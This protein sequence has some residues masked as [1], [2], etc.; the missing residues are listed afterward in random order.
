MTKKTKR[1][2]LRYVVLGTLLFVGVVPL[3][4]TGWFLS[5]RSGRELRAAEGRYQTELVRD[6]A[7]RIEVFGRRYVRLVDHYKDLFEF[8]KDEL[9]L[10]S[11]DVQQRLALEIEEDGSLLALFVR[12]VKGESLSA[13][14]AEKIDQ[15]EIERISGEVLSS[16]GDT[17]AVIG[18][19]EA[20]EKN[21]E[22]VLAIATPVVIDNQMV[23]AVVA[24]TSLR[25]IASA[26]MEEKASE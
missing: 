11:V 25:G 5:D 26:V 7:N 17:G 19:P 22:L 8:R 3:M 9:A 4:I 12:P 21:G 14:R 15:G 6:K 10:S 20:I 18:Q 13:Y 24:I 23:A 1:F 16:L 2:S